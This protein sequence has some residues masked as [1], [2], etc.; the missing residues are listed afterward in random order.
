VPPPSSRAV[1]VCAMLA[2][3]APLGEQVPR[4][5]APDR[6]EGDGSG[7]VIAASAAITGAQPISPLRPKSG[8]TQREQRR[9]EVGHDDYFRVTAV[10]A[11]TPGGQRTVL[12]AQ[13]LDEIN[14]GTEAAVGALVIGLP[15]LILIVGAATFHFVGRTLRP[16]DAMRRQAA[17]ITGSSLHNRLPVPA[18]RDEIAAL[19]E[20]MNTMLDRIEAAT[21]AQR[22]FVAD[23]SHEL[24]SP[25][26]TVHAGLDLLEAA[27]LPPAAAAHVTRMHRE[28]ERMTRLVGDLLLLARVDESGLSLRREDVDLDDLVYTER[29]RLAA[30]RPDLRVTAGVTP[31]RVHGD[32]PKLHRALRNL[33]D[34]AAKHAKNTVDID[35]A[36]RPDAVELTVADDGA[37]IPPADRERV[38]DRF[39]RLGDDRSRQRGGTGLGLPIARD[40][41]TAHGGP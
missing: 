23:A 5:A 33:V 10:G 15:V 22:R 1:A 19:A 6:H 35:L 28:S 3:V 27:E 36:Q 9:I 40:I 29:D 37:G 16:V 26:A 41:V 18:A 7:R 12:V 30:E 34:N 39:V 13:S 24:R 21:A 38:F 14:D 20:T 31:I 8:Q 25:L 4:V 32:P 17:T 11:G 2:G